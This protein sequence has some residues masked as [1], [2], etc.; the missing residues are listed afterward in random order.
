MGPPQVLA[1]QSEKT[2]RGGSRTN[3]SG[4]VPSPDGSLGKGPD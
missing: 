3:H 2:R 1:R 4:R